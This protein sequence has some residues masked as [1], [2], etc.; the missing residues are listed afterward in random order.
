[1]GEAVKPRKMMSGW[2]GLPAVSLIVAPAMVSSMAPV[3][4]GIP[5]R[6]TSR[7]PST[8][9]AAGISSR[10]SPEP[11]SGVLPTTSMSGSMV[12]GALCACT[13][14]ACVSAKPSERT[15]G[16]RRMLSDPSA[17]APW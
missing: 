13:P 4:L 7:G 12:A 2:K 8:L 17:T 11:S 3:R 1:M 15:R 5:V 10:S 9:V 16:K 14:R 6:F